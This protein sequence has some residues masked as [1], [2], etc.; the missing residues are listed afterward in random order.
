MSPY[1][2]FGCFI[3]FVTV[4]KVVDLYDYR[5][6]NEVNSSHLIVSF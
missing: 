3:I 5:E 2:G 1:V 4:L 6:L